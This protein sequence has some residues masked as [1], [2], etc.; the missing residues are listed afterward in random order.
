LR[1][2]SIM[3]PVVRFMR[4][5]VLCILIAPPSGLRADGGTMRLL[6]RVGGYR[7][8]V[9]TDPTPLRA[10]SVDVS[11]FVQDADTGEPAAG[12]QIMVQAAPRGRPDQAVGHAATAEAATN[13]LFRSA[14]FELPESGWWDIE[15]KVDGERGQGRVRFDVEVADRPPSWETLAPW[16]GWPALAVL[17]FAV[18]QALV[19]RKARIA[20]KTR[21]LLAQGKIL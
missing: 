2:A 15:A 7:I 4:L 11:V 18:H 1:T 16:V 8:T 14:I 17:L 12:V 20:K 9:F 6:E 13:K 5:S 19:R 3:N 21:T 10:G